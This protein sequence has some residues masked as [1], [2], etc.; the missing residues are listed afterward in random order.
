MKPIEARITA[1]ERAK[2]KPLPYYAFTLENGR[3]AYFDALDA[4]LYLARMKAGIEE[5]ITAATRYK[6]NLPKAG[7]AWADLENEISSIT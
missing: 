3:E 7:T 1:L 2:K 5:N 4:H 6:G